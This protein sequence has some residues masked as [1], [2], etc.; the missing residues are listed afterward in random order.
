MGLS[1]ADRTIEQHSLRQ[2]L[3]PADLPV[4]E[5]SEQ[6]NGNADKHPLGEETPC[7]TYAPTR[8]IQC[9]FGSA[10]RAAR[11]R[12][13][14]RSSAWK[15]VRYVSGVILRSMPMDG[16]DYRARAASART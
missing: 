14:V 15:G 4:D 9:D 7:G 16:P 13:T 11:H 6:L 3:N 2:G 12:Q 5:I 8:S 10:R 1:L